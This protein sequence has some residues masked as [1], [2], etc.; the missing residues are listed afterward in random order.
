LVPYSAM[1][2]VPRPVVTYLARL[3]AAYRRTISTPRRS[4]ALTPFRQAVM[5]LR[6]F[7]DGSRADALARDHA[8]SLA[9]AY[10]YVHEGIDVLAAQ[11]PEL[12]Q[13]LCELRDRDESL[14][15]LEGKV[16]ATTRCAQPGERGTDVWYSAHKHHHGPNIQFFADAAGSPLCVFDAEPGSVSELGA[17]HP[18]PAAAAPRRGPRG[19][20]GAG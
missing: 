6:W 5:V 17:A 10:R 20:D 13:V 2:D 8:V 19:P 18:R 1:L 14:A 16:F 4:R 7:R 3:L 11:A 9:T 12:Q 15:I